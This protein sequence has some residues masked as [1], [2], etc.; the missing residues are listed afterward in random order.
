MVVAALLL[1]VVVIPTFFLI[2]ISFWRYADYDMTP[3]LT[4]S[5]YAR[6]IEDDTYFSL[7]LQSVAVSAAAATA[8]TA[9]GG[10]SAYAILR[11]PQPVRMPVLIALAA[12]FLVGEVLRLVGLRGLLDPASAFAAAIHSWGYT[13]P[14]WLMFSDQATALG[15]V[16]SWV[17]VPV[18]LC[19]ASLSN[20]LGRYEAI[21]ASLGARP[22]HIISRIL[23]PL[24][25]P[26][27]AASF[28]VVLIAGFTS[29]LPADALGGA[30]GANLPV[31]IG[32]VI[33]DTANWPFGAVLCLLL[34]LASA[35]SAFTLLRLVGRWAR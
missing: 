10:A 24:N 30:R 31:A 28:V 33:K 23:L 35:A 32:T 34:L 11:L 21:A 12:P 19:Y 3:A 29:A 27:V 8:A 13:Y 17:T 4:L 1:A 7:L 16:Q 20:T 2:I 26:A 6:L 14:S 18:I 25:L 5:N 9:L 15:I 22:G